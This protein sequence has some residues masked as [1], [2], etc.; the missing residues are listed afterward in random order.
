MGIRWRKRPSARFVSTG[1]VSRASTLS[2][3]S[4]SADPGVRELADSGRKPGVQP[5]PR[6]AAAANAPRLAR[7]SRRRVMSSSR[8]RI[9]SQLKVQ[10]LARGALTAF[11]VKWR[12]RAHCRPQP[13]PFPA[14]FRIVDPAV[15]PLRIKPHGI[16]DAQHDPFPVLQDDQPFRSIAGVD[17]QVRA[18]AECPELID[19]GVVARLGAPR[20]RY[21]LELRQR[22]RVKGP[23]FGAMLARGL[24]AIEWAFALPAVEAREMPTRESRPVDAV[25]VHIAAA[26][27]EPF[28]RLARLIERQFLQ[29]CEG[30]LGRTRLGVEA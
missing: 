16:G 30:R 19:P 5:R 26:R 21:A 23:T 12:A 25:S 20:R 9:G 10:D 11:H 24:R 14:A 28:D 18:Q 13:P 3:Y 6:G 2:Q 17:R 4:R 8:E 7:N 1:S 27:R 15:H 29:L 22:L